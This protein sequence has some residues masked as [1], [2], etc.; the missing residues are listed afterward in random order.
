[1]ARR[2]KQDENQSQENVDN[3]DDTFGLPEIEYEPI[4]RDKPEAETESEPESEPTEQPVAEES[5]SSETTEVHYEHEDANH[6]EPVYEEEEEE[7]SSVWPKILGIIAILVLA[8]A[9][10]WYFVVYRPKQAAEEKARQEQ[11]ARADSVKRAQEEE[12]RG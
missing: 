4:N 6:A 11:Q 9:G 8:G 7:G 5:S 10:V 3:T 1:M 2:K 12:G